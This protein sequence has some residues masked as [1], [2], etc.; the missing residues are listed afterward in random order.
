MKIK[1]I[2]LILFFNLTI[3]SYAQISEVTRFPLQD[4]NQNN[5]ESFLLGLTN[6]H[7]IIFWFDVTNYQIKLSRSS[8]NGGN[9][10]DPSILANISTSETQF[11]I[12]ALLLNTGRLLFTYK[13]SIYYSIYSDDGGYTWSTPAQLPV[14]LNIIQKRMINLTSL[15]KN[16]NGEVFFIFSKNTTSINPSTAKGI[17][18]ISSSDGITWSSIDTID[19]NGRNGQ[20][21]ILDTNK[22]MIAFEDSVSNQYDIYFRTSTNSGLDWSEREILISNS[23]SKKNARGIKDFNG[24]IRIFY[25][26]YNQTPFDG[27]TQTDIHFISSTDYGNNWSTPE[28][29][30][31]YIGND[32]NH[33]VSIWNGKPIIAFSSSRNFSNTSNYYQI[34]FTLA[35]VLID[36]NVPPFMYQFT[37]FPLA[38][39]PNQLFYIRAFAD[40]DSGLNSVKL[41]LQ[42]SSGLNE[43]LNMYDDGIHNDLLSGDKIYGIDN[44]S[45]NY[46]DTL[47]YHFVIE[48]NQQNVVHFS[49]ETIVVQIPFA[50][51]GYLFDVNNF[52]LPI[53]NRGILADVLVDNHIR[54]TYEESTVLFSGGFYVSGF[55]NGVPW[56]NAIASASN[57]KDYQAGPVGSLP[58]DPYNKL[59]I[60]N[61]ADPPFG[62][63]WFFYQ[64]AVQL[65]AS[66][67]DGNGD[68]I[69]LPWDNNGNG[70][71]DIDE[72]RPDIL[73]DVTAWCVYNDGVPSNLR[74]W[75]DIQ[76]M[77]IE[78]QQT[79]FAWGENVND[80]IDNM[81]FVRYKIINKGTVSNRFDDV[82]FS[83]WADPDIGAS[84]ASN[85]DLVGCDTLLNIGY[86]YNDG[87]DE[88]FGIN[89]PALGIP[90][91]QGPAVFI[92]NVTY[93]DINGDGIYNEGIDT[94]LDS[95]QINS[96][97][98]LGVI[99]VP[100]AT[101]QGL[102][103]F[104]HYMN[105]NPVMG[106][107]DLSFM[108]RNYMKGLD[109]FGFSIDPCT[110][111][112]GQ[113]LG[114]INCSDVNPKYMYSGD[115]IF[116]NGWINN[117]PVDQRTLVNT[118][119]FILEQ[120][121]PIEILV[122]YV[123]GR[124][125]DALNSVSLMKEYCQEAI[126][127]YNSNFTDIPTIIED[128][129]NIIKD[130]SLSQNYPNPF[131]PT[132]TIKYYI[133]NAVSVKLIIYDL[134]GRE[135][136][137]LVNDFQQRGEHSIEFDGSSLSSGVYFYSLM[138]GDFM[139]TKKLILMK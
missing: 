129:Q 113:V 29:F 32:D 134:L 10:S 95:A 64:N 136:K 80:P 45:F 130:F 69:Y 49:G 31:K 101:N 139:Q 55:N 40:D 17:Y 86:I 35:D 109:Q 124:G 103:S 74:K 137:T 83:A 99:K 19:I 98:V 79:T 27:I 34:Y 9:W 24:V 66:F 68:G 25:Q 71:W 127:I 110:W 53:D 123:I 14:A 116:S 20:L 62:D 22:D 13:S 11:D 42:I 125:A 15:A 21:I 112:Y 65:G 89:P 138:A 119:P 37:H 131:N 58:T 102:S 133:P 85:D 38:P 87:P 78:I 93:I 122:C 33:N 2:L 57:I 84:S 128:Q 16:T 46:G 43:I 63:S 77:G 72:D 23:F 96:G 94:P 3:F 104:I 44:I 60:L 100:G 76:P 121:N 135:I 8:D 56:V 115:P 105:G 82:Y 59:Y 126:D 36:T 90:F 48:D 6:N 81:I 28:K 51:D 88:V 120:D 67:Y 75:N 106:D 97:P 108:A 52:K 70:S 18:S 12:N 50:T 54:G 61:A 91:L 41:H 132:T 73:G 111:S 1:N 4:A 92:P 39:V 47:V 5:K 118:G 107:P 114:G 30:T 117:F 7:L 26:Q